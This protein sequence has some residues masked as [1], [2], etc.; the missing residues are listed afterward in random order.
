MVKFIRAYLKTKSRLY[1]LIIKFY[2]TKDLTDR[3]FD[4]FSK[5][6]NKKVNF[7]QIGVS[8]GLRWDSIR[9]YVV[10]DKWNEI[11]IEP[12]PSRGLKL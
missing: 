7:I 1:D 11:L 6:Q 3:F 4:E 9:K 2:R 5:S 8:D 12:L 10:R